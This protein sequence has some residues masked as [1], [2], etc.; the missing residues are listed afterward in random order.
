MMQRADYPL[1][2]RLNGVA[3]THLVDGAEPAPHMSHAF[4]LEISLVQEL[5]RGHRREL[6]GFDRLE[7]RDS[8]RRSRL[9]RSIEC[10]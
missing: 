6:S 4:F 3:D 5:Y 7:I 2:T 8:K 1:R 9:V 10:T